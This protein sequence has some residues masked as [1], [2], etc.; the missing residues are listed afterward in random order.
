MFDAI[1]QFGSEIWTFFLGTISVL[2]HYLQLLILSTLPMLELRFAIPYGLF[3]LH[4]PWW[5]VLF[6]C[7][8]GNLLPNVII[9][10]LLPIFGDWLR[11]RI[12]LFDRFLL[13]LHDN[14]KEDFKKKGM[15]FIV[16]FVGIPIPGSGSWTGSLLAY[17]FDLSYKRS[18]TVISIGVVMS[19][20]IVMTL[21]LGG[22]AVVRS[23]FW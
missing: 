17:L 14:H 9:L 12:G 22:W 15:W 11:K 20:V 13:R 10:Y 18:L 5:Y 19:G 16:F 6:W 23:I 21:S 3:A 8:L 2:P 7:V 4:E 1:S